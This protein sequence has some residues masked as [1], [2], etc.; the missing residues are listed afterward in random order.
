VGQTIVNRGPVT[1]A[2]NAPHRNEV[3]ESFIQNRV[4]NTQI[5]AT[6]PVVFQQQSVQQTI[7]VQQPQ[8]IRQAANILPV[9]QQTIFQNQQAQQI[10]VNIPQE[11]QVA[12]VSNMTFQHQSNVSSVPVPSASTPYQA[13]KTNS[14]YV[15]P[16]VLTK[17]NSVERVDSK[18]VF[19]DN[20][21][22]QGKGGANLVFTG[23]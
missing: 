9:Q 22:P 23:N 5:N 8:I 15:A 4:I 3:K 21:N 14:V 19:M 6:Q 7:F 16:Q 10:Q 1:F 13:T 11:Q 2:N 17:I 20:N 12:R 18:T